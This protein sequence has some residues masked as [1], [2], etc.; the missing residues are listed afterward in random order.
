MQRQSPGSNNCGVYA[1]A[2][3][4]AILLK[5]NPSEIKFNEDSMSH[6][7]CECFDKKSI[8]KLSLI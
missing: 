5:D 3:C 2:V 8:D 4:M 1:I 7:L 6:H